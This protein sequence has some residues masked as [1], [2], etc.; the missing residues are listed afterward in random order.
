MA[1]RFEV[2]NKTIVYKGFFQLEKYRLRHELFAG[3]WTP[4]IT[5][6][7]LER[8]HAVA[9]LPYDPVRDR[10]VLLEQFRIGALTAPGGPWL[11]EIVA[12]VIGPGESRLEVARREA[13][14]EAGCDLLDIIPVCEYLVS[15]GGASESIAL[16]C[17]RV[18]A[19]GIAG[20]HG[21]AEEHE[22]IRAHVLPSGEALALLQAGRILSATA[23]IAL[24]WFALN[25][26]QLRQRWGAPP[27]GG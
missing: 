7:C 19:A 24:Q 8:G 15:P 12:G 22:D 16:Y 10:L 23:V 5:R 9:V 6:E 20:V 1:Y 13:K 4:A 14:E 17:A 27:V 18:D 21:L 3:G 2:L 25:R 11:L 26:E